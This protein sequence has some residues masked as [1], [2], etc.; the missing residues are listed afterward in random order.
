MNKGTVTGEVQ[1]PREIVCIETLKLEERDS[2][3]DAVWSQREEISLISLVEKIGTKW[4]D[5]SKRIGTKSKLQVRSMSLHLRQ[6]SL[7]TLH[8]YLMFLLLS[9]SA[10][11]DTKN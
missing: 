10:N 6:F 1:A 9:F 2:I 11:L 7:V 5:I 8:T 4:D 3:E